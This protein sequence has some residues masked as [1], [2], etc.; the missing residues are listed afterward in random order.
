M[1]FRIYSN[2]GG[3]HPGF[4]LPQISPYKQSY[5]TGEMDTAARPRRPALSD[6]SLPGQQRWISLS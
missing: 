4:I 6:L 5:V 3:H 1:C 2:T